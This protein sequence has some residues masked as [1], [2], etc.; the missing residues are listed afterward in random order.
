MNNKGFT[1]VELLAMLVVLAILMGIAIPNITGILANNKVNVM[2][3]DASKM[4]DT[5]K[6][7][8]SRIPS[9]ERP[10][11]GQCVI[12]ALNYLND[13]GDITNGPNGGKYLQFDSFIVISRHGSQFDYYIRLIEE[14]GT[15]RIGMNLVERKV[16]SQDDTSYIK[17]IK[18]ADLLKLGGDK[19]GDLAV[20]NASSSTAIRQLCPS[21]VVDYYPGR[22]TN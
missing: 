5:A 4:T 19:E 10:K 6:M 14:D 7:K 11:A 15:K 21:G 9:P 18:E 8:F 2:K 20:L 16:L 17:S 3:A 22:V 12:Y 1:L 13:N